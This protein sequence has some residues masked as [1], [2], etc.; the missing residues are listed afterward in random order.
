M[1]GIN[2]F[3]IF[4]LPVLLLTPLILVTYLPSYLKGNTTVDGKL[5]TDLSLHS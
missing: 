4:S 3:V 2:I 1:L 5:A